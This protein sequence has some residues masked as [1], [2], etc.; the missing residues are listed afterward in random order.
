MKTFTKMGIAFLIV[1]CLLLVGLFALV[2]WFVVGGF[3]SSPLPF[4]LGNIV[5]FLFQ[6]GI[7]WYLFVIVGAILIVIGAVQKNPDNP[8]PVTNQP[9]R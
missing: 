7:S 6:L 4:P 9:N 8:Q 3:G 5:Q 2:S 1:G